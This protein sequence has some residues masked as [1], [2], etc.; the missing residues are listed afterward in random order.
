[1]PDKAAQVLG[2]NIS[3]PTGLILVALSGGL[4]A[5]GKA[6][7]SEDI[8]AQDFARIVD[9]KIA[10]REE[11]IDLKLDAV[12]DRLGRMERKL[13]DLSEAP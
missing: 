11:V 6:M 10:A 1:M 13:D 5:G 12:V 2:G 3:V 8:S 9:E 7:M 4:G